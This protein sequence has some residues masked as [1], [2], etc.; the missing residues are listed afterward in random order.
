MVLPRSSSCMR[1]LLSQYL[2]PK[3]QTSNC[4]YSALFRPRRWFNHRACRRGEEGAQQNKGDQNHWCQCFPEI[5]CP[6]CAPV[7]ASRRHRCGLEIARALDVRPLLP[8]IYFQL[9]HVC[10]WPSCTDFSFSTVVVRLYLPEWKMLKPALI[11]ILILTSR[12]YCHLKFC[13]WIS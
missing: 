13:I 3:T 9:L 11:M 4:A 5:S 6:P 7:C 10:L 8:G 12:P 1:F 2:H